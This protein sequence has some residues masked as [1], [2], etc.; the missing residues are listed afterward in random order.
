VVIEQELPDDLKGKSSEKP[1]GEASLRGHLKGDGKEETNAALSAYVPKEPEKDTQLKYALSF[2]R[3]Q[4]ETVQKVEPKASAATETPA[5]KDM[6][7]PN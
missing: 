5:A 4:V 1:R 3:D 2:V 6:P 7:K